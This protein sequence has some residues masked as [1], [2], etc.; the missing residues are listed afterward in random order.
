MWR[1]PLGHPETGT[2]PGELTFALQEQVSKNK[3]RSIGSVHCAL[4]VKAK[5]QQGAGA[6]ISGGGPLSARGPRNRGWRAPRSQSTR[7]SGNDSSMRKGPGVGLH[8]QD[9]F[10]GHVSSLVPC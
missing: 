7:A 10:P 6:A 3:W 4:G 1:L 9:A 2:D 5:E 8:D